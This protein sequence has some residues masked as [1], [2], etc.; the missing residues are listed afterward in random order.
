MA[1][2]LKFS[3]K[4]K[5]KEDRFIESLFSFQK[6][7]DANKKPIIIAVISIVFIG[8]VTFI[9]VNIRSRTNEEAREIFGEALLE[10]QSG[11]FSN[12]ISKLKK[13][14]DNYTSTSSASKAVFLL[15]SLYYELG[16]YSLAVEAYKRY[17]EKYDENDFLNTAVYKGLG[18]AYI[19]LKDH[20]NAISAFQTAIKKYPDNFNIPEIRY[21]LARCYI[22]KQNLENAR[23]ELNLIIQQYP[24]STYAKEAKLMLASI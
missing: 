6:K 14:A 22:E 2:E 23:A 18:S 20:D 8:I 17:I 16:N 1:V 10:Y 24:Q 12:T 11:K 4:H 3:K 7:V 21:K 15:G 5:I 13:I 19:Q 9:S